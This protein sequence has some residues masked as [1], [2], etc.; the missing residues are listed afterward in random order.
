MGPSFYW[1][2]DVFER[3]FSQFGK[4]VSDYYTLER[5]D[6]SYRIYWNDGFTDIPASFEELKEVFESFE[7]G[8][9]EKLEKYLKEAAYKYEVGINKLVYKPGLSFSEFIDWS[10][11]KGVFKLEV[12]SL[13]L[14]NIF[15]NIFSIQSFVR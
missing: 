2:P 7:K 6:P 13:L 11:I 5:L 12:S 9:A 4:K 8:S 1:M 14:K 10:V 3:Y 15:K